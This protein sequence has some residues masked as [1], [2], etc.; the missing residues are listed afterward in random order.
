MEGESVKITEL[1]NVSVGIER[2]E[3][4]TLFRLSIQ[5]PHTHEM[6]WLAFGQDTADAILAAL[7]GIQVVQRLP[8]H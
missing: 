2:I 4:Q 1:R 3:G 6:L 8:G 5:D 7:T